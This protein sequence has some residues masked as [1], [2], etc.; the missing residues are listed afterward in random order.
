MTVKEKREHARL[1]DKWATMRATMKEMLRCM[2]LDRK[3]KAEKARV[4]A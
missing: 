4:N 1:Q 3:A 2:A